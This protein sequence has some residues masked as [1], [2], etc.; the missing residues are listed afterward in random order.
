M[1]LVSMT[2]VEQRSV[3]VKCVALRRTE[4]KKKKKTRRV[5]YMYCVFM[6]IYIC[7]V[8]TISAYIG[9]SKKETNG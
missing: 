4:S 2:A 3:T 9:E 5:V 6:Y 8:S 7:T 1:D